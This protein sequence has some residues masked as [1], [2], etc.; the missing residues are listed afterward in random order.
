MLGPSP[1]PL[2]A[3]QRAGSGSGSVYAG[4]PKARRWELCARRLAREKNAVRLGWVQQRSKDGEVPYADVRQQGLQLYRDSARQRAEE[5]LFSRCTMH[6]RAF[7]LAL[8]GRGPGK[9]KKKVIWYDPR[10][11]MRGKLGKRKKTAGKREEKR[12]DESLAQERRDG[13]LDETRSRL[14]SD[15]Y[16]NRSRTLFFGRLVSTMRTCVSLGSR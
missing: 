5:T 12:N 8:A 6:P 16:G 2:S 4:V 14:R 15:N 10:S 9:E 11:T 7:G 13:V 3:L 1:V